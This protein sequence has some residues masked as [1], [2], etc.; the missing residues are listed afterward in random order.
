MIS[1]LLQAGPWILAALGI[2]GGLLTHWRST[3]NVAAANQK[4][5]EAQTSAAQVQ[6][7]AAQANATAAQAGAQASKDRENVENDIAAL[8]AGGAAQQLRDGWS[9]D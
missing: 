6:D 5:A 1:L 9:R 8:P 3:A 7:A 4:V 2:V